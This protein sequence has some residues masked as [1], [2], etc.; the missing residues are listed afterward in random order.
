MNFAQIDTIAELTA[1][2]TRR[3]RMFDALESIH[4]YCKE[5]LID[6]YDINQLQLKIDHM[7][8]EILNACEKEVEVIRLA[9]S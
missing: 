3:D 4:S 2:Y 1:S 6:E 5:Q 9:N 7:R 8:D